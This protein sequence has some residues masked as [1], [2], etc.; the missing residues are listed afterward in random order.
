MSQAPPPRKKPRLEESAP[1][2][3]PVQ[4]TPLAN[5]KP[6]LQVSN[7]T[8]AVKQEPS[9]GQKPDEKPDEKYFNV[10]W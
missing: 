8:D 10:L 3:Q 9:A 6:L 4:S 1:D 5:R 2:V 7:R